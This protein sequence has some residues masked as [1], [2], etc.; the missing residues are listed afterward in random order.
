MA[1]SPRAT[2]DLKISSPATV[3]AIQRELAIWIDCNFNREEIFR[4]STSILRS[5]S[6]F[7]MV[8]IVGQEELVST[9]AAKNSSLLVSYFGVSWEVQVG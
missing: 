9:K 5:D 3:E 4:K 2:R 1:S 7:G 8:M 6:K